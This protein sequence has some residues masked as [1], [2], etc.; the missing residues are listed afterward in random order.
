MRL[1]V[2]R[3]PPHS[4]TS[5][6]GSY[7][8]S[9]PE[10]HQKAPSS[11]WLQHR[12][13]RGQGVRATG[14]LRSSLTGCELFSQPSPLRT[15]TGGECIASSPTWV[16]PWLYHFLPSLTVCVPTGTRVP[17]G[18]RGR[19]TGTAEAAG[20]DAGRTPPP[21]DCVT[22]LTRQQELMGPWICA[23]LGGPREGRV[24]LP[25]PFH[26]SLYQRHTP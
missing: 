10:S 9:P 15:R 12:D 7:G 26:F 6:P 14:L 5:P 4:G 19:S 2:A 20:L 21:S 22:L 13:H 18:R 25:P 11:P 16:G 24:Q 1:R 17:S 8:A 3:L 23:E